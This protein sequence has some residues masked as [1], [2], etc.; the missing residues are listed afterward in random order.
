MK[1]LLPVL[2]LLCFFQR[3]SSQN[4]TPV[5]ISFRDIPDSSSS[6]VYLYLLSNRLGEQSLVDSVVVTDNNKASLHIPDGNEAGLYT[7]LIYARVNGQTMQ[8]TFNFLFDKK[9]IEFNTC[10]KTPVDSMKVLSSGVNEK[11][12]SFIKQKKYY[13]TYYSKLLELK[14]MTSLENT[15]YQVLNRQIIKVLSDQSKLFTKIRYDSSD[16]IASKYNRW[17]LSSE[18]YANEM[19]NVEYLRNHFLDRFDFTDSFIKNTDLLTA[20]TSSYLFLYKD[21][22]LTPAGQE[23]QLLAAVDKMMACY[24]VDEEIVH[25]V[26]SELEK[27]FE[28]LGMEKVMIHIAD[29]YLLNSSGCTNS[30]A[31]EKLKDEVEL[32][33]QLQP[34]HLAPNLKFDIDGIETLYDVKSDSVVVLFWATWCSHC[35]Q[36][37]PEIYAMLKNRPSVKVVAI[38]LD[39]DTEA[40]REGT[41]KFPGWIHIQAKNMWDDKLVTPYAV[42]ATPTI[43]LLGSNHKIVKKIKSVPE[44]KGVM[45][46]LN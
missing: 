6:H 22:G 27:E 43:Y 41:K 4:I 1:R 28:K 13:S 33:K 12:F 26:A 40:W 16:N 30:E 39:A 7:T 34:G 14:S 8:S 21:A 19:N 15:F 44:L 36:S 9:S 45:K 32:L 42:Y 10:L 25:Y 18:I 37:V 5:R 17:L 35:R 29:S 46:N 24:S 38:A 3:V 31:W 11:Y 2:I 23:Q 20:I